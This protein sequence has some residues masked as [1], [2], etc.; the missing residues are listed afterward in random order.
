MV[1]VQIDLQ[2]DI[3]MIYKPRLSEE[4]LAVRDRGDPRR[5]ACGPG[6][7]RKTSYDA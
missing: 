5:Q 7:I 6:F 1:R 2:E 4:A 3:L